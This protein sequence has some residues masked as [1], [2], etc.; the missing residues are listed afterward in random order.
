MITFKMLGIQTS[1][2]HHSLRLINVNTS[3]LIKVCHLL[4]EMWLYYYYYYYIIAKVFS[5]FIS[6]SEMQE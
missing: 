2:M 1:T 3:D 5:V 6:V 4:A